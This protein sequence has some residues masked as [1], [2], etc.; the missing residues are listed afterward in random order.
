MTMQNRSVVSTCHRENRSEVSAQIVESTTFK[1]PFWLARPPHPFAFAT[2]TF[3][4]SFEIALFFPPQ[5]LQLQGDPVQSQECAEHATERRFAFSGSSAQALSVTVFLSQ[6]LM[7]QQH[8]GGPP[9]RGSRVRSRLFWNL[10]SISHV[11][12]GAQSS[13]CILISQGQ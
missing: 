10:R 6:T 5:G 2:L 12:I 13:P 3:F 8:R 7:L 1:S 4:F 11:A 9:R